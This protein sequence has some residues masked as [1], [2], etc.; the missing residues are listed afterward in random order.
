MNT[1]I[2]FKPVNVNRGRKFKGFA[3][4]LGCT[5]TNEIAWRVTAESTKLWDPAEKRY[6][7][8]NPDFCEDAT[9]EASKVE[10][11]LNDYIKTTIDGTLRWCRSQKPSAAESEVKQF[12]RNV[13]RKQHPEMLEF[14]DATIADQRDVVAEIERTL[15]WAMALTTRACWMYGR[16]CAGGRPLPVERK[17][18]SALNA[19]SKRGI[20]QLD[21]FDE[22][23]TFSLTV[24]GLPILDR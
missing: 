24:R 19:L 17:V 10:A 11:D 22:A 3:Y 15:E 2:T 20:T 12:A 16:W 5:Y 9:V 13:L 6:V 1:K 8:A 7:Y 23:W 21:G 14:I 4:F 18:R